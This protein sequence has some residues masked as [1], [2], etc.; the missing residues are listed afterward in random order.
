[1]R[2][3]IIR[4]IGPLREVDIVLNRFNVILGIQ[5]SGKS[6]VLRIASYCAWVEKQ[7]QL[8]QSSSMFEY[9]TSFM[10]MLCSYHKMTEYVHEDSYISY[11]T[12]TMWFSY[13]HKSKRFSFEWNEKG[14]Y[15]YRLPKI[16]YIPTE[17]N[18]V[19]LLPNWKNEVRAYDCVLDFMRD[20]D[21]AR[22]A[23]GKTG[24]IFNLRMNYFFNKSVEDDYIQ[25]K[26]GKS[27]HL[28]N[29]SSGVQSLV[30]LFVT[31][32]YITRTIYLQEASEILNQT[33]AK[34]EKMDRLI[35]LLYANIKRSQLE[36]TPTE[37]YE[38]QVVRHKER[39]YR[40][41]NIESSKI[42][43]SLV[44]N[45]MTYQQTDI[46]LEEPENNL[47]P[48]TQCMLMDWLDAKT[49]QHTHPTSIFIATHSPYVLTYL[50]D[51]NVRGKRFFF[52]YE[53]PEAKGVYKVKALT[54]QEIDQIVANG[55]DMF[56]NYESYI[57]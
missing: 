25:L 51:K 47:F 13:D 24:E 2:Q 35:D 20:W 14:R 41:K 48:S 11:E 5:S 6:C 39:E 8:S 19:S 52:T 54:P 10:D 17:R 27:L 22:R 9:G 42:F 34:R 36:L 46:Y 1:M 57:E 37:G 15:G 31:I 38:E 4:N 40:F 18:I 32:D 23:I 33:E 53:D 50:M 56:Y 49:R 45:Y 3:L 12:D 43:A 29:T 7:I 30:P 21:K 55:V 26:D 28:S 16:S 44:V